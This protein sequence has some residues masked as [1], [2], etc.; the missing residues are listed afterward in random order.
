MNTGEKKSPSI[1]RKL[2]VYKKNDFESTS[3]AFMPTKPN[4]TDECNITN[5]VNTTY[6]YGYN[7]CL[8]GSR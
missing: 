3:V 2:F 4:A 7:I 8:Y 6:L 5:N 1:L